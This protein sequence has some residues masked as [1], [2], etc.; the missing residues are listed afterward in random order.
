MREVSI[1]IKAGLKKELM[2]FCRTRK[3]LVI[4]LVMIGLAALSPILITA[5][6]SL[7][8]SMGDIGVDVSEITD[9]FGGSATSVGVSASVSDV[10]DLGL[11]VF[12]L[13]IYRAAGG[14]QK[15]RAVI[16]PKS[17]GLRSLGYIFPKYIVYPP[18]ALL[19]SI[20][21]IFASW[22]ISAMI[23]SV[24]DLTFDTVLLVG[25]LTGV[26]MMLYVSF[27]LAL[28]TATG[29]AGLSAAV[30]IGASLILPN[31]F[32]LSG[33][34]YMLNPF[35]IEILAAQLAQLAVHPELS[36][37]A[38]RDIAL[39][40]GFAV[41]LMVLS[42]LIALFAQNAKRIDNTDDEISKAL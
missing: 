40:V 15:K 17:A 34:D 31:V 39:T 36:A 23:F 9:V 12:L 42:F 8:S 4:A 2:A 21:A 6:G 11:I 13:L 35:A 5:M 22:G 14:E 7:M 20:I 30:C 24:N 28:G 29:K 32:A 18:A 33:S 10:R 37:S 41:L 27:H 16:I 19:L 38:A 26:S 25:I 1:Q 3:F